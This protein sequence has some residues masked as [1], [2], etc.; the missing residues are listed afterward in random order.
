M[1][2]MVYEHV[3][4]RNFEIIESFLSKFHEIFHSTSPSN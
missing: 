3:L 4:A 2:I 1:S